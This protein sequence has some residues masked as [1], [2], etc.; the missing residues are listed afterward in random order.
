MALASSRLSGHGRDSRYCGVLHL[1]E[2]C[3]SVNSTCVHVSSKNV[4]LEKDRRLCSSGR[5]T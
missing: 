5:M 2:R 1:P 3:F 4:A